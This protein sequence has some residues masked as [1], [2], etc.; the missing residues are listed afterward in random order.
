MA[1]TCY[2]AKLIAKNSNLDDLVSPYM[3][4]LQ[5]LI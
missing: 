4:S 3:Y 2:L 1:Q 5:E